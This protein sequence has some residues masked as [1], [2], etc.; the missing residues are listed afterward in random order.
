MASELK[1]LI[2]Q[3]SREK[4][5]DRQTLINTL[6]EAIKSAIKK[7]Y[8]NR[9]DLD[10]TFNEEFGEIEAFQFK[11]VV[12]QVT[13]HEKEVSLEEALALDPEVELGDEL[14]I[15]MN[16]DA[17]G[18]I[19]AQSAKQVIIQKMKDAE[20]EVVYDEFKG[21]KGEIVHGIV[22]RVDKNGITVNLG[23]AEALL[24][25][26]EQI[27]REVFRQGD[28]I[29]AYVLE[30]KKISKGPQIILSRTHPH[31]L[32]QLFHSEVP[33]IAEGIVS[34]ISA[35]REPGSRAKIAVVSKNPD[36][37]PVGACVGMK[38]SRVQNVVQELR[39]EKIDIVP[40]N[41]DPA[42]FV[43]NALAPAIISKVIIDQNNRSMEV[44]VPDDQLSLAI[45]KRGQ[46]VRLASRLTNWR[47]DVNSESRYGRKKQAGYQAL[48]QIKGLTTEM[49]DRLYEAGITSLQDFLEAGTTELEDL[50][51]LSEAAVSEMK[52]EAK[53]LLSTRVAGTVTDSEDS[54]KMSESKGGSEEEA[55]QVSE[56]SMDERST[57]GTSSENVTGE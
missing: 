43:V 52:E 49:A 55:P 17:L 46:N 13:D 11:E 56:V 50:T 15:R 19:A 38:G 6:E 4:G 40:W 35:N 25:A 8:G 36:V 2:D 33:E 51:R 44:I 23:Q 45:G 42:K 39:G 12:E 31:F 54:V 37:D 5:I 1:R 21:R 9:F 10:V 28:R 20:R 22:Q 24:P 47:I 41:M 57:A 48:L 32:I 53:I 26:K 30:V 3:V 7:K 27:P 14:G 18:R 16:T 29:R 34:I